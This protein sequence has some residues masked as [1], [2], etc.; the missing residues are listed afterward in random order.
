[1]LASRC[2]VIGIGSDIGGSIRIPSAFCGVYGLKPGVGR[3][4]EKGE[5]EMEAA[6]NGMLN[7]RPSKGPM[8]RCVDDLIILSKV[9]FRRDYYENLN[10]EQQDFYWQPEELKEL[11]Q[12]KLK[13]G[14]IEQFNELTP[15]NCMKRGVFEACEALRRKGHEVVP[16]QIDKQLDSDLVAAFPK[17]VSAEG[18]FRSF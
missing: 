4:S 10:H 2:S 1:M 18:G 3:I 5:G 12:R 15:P 13:I 7:I 11:P 14:Y 6:V 8:A 17:I 9:L 16:F